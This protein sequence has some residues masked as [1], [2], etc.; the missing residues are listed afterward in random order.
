MKLLLENWRQYIAEDEAAYFP[1]LKALK[2]QGTEILFDEKKFKRIGSGAFRV[3]F[4]PIGDKE[5]VVKISKEKN[6]NWMNQI[7]SKLG[8]EYPAIFPKTFVHS[9]DWEW[10]V[11]E[12]VEVITRK[13][14][15]K[16][17]TMLSVS[18]PDF[19]MDYGTT[20]EYEDPYELWFMI[21]QSIENPITNDEKEFQDFGLNTSS[22][23]YRQLSSAVHRHNMDPEDLD[24]G[25]IGINKDGELRIHD[26]SVFVKPENL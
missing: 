2:E 18:F 8:N 6:L 1:W 5:H 12:A 9:D 26:A 25:N 20:E 11:Q 23:V 10:M 24:L 17:E 3:V 7:E 16:L 15:D 4:Q 13:N 19:H 14:L 21:R 22:G